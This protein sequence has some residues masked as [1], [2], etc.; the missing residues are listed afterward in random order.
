[1]SGNPHPCRVYGLMAAEAPVCVL[2]RRGPSKWT[3][4]IRWD[5][6]TDSF[7]H[8]DWFDGRVYEYKSDIS[9]DGRYWCYF[10]MRPRSGLDSKAIGRCWQWSAISRVPEFEPLRVWPQKHGWYGGGRF[11][12]NR[13]VMPMIDPKEFVL[14]PGL[15]EGD[16]VVLPATD[17][18]WDSIESVARPG[19]WFSRASELGGGYF[20]PAE[21]DRVLQMIEATGASQKP[22]TYTGIVRSKDGAEVELQRCQWVDVDQQ[23]RI[24]FARDG[25]VYRW[26]GPGTERALVDLNESRPPER[27]AE[28]GVE[29]PP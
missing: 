23:G 12:T 3:Q 6:A 8:G 10:V 21:E 2:L 16:F 4:V 26:D 19:G 13:H 1:M 25:V 11:V 7:E 28:G 20:K 15:L 18:A 24:V 5:T 29:P 9:P 22:T 27:R 14:E 17:P